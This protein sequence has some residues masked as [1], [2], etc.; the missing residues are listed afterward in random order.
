MER[1]IQTTYCYRLRPTAGQENH[2]HDKTSKQ[3][4]STADLEAELVRL[5]QHPAT[6]WLR[7]MESQS[8][9]QALRDLD[10][11]YHT[12]S[13]VPNRSTKRL[14]SRASNPDITIRRAF[15]FRNG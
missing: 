9:Q 13:G 3:Y 7:E 2:E 4:L 6:A 5:K 12:S 8:L 14:V 10:A 15:A 11:A 1:T